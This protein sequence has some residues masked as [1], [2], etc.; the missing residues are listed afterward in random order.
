VPAEELENEEW[1]YYEDKESSN[2]LWLVRNYQEQEKDGFD[3]Y[4]RY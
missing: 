3:L 4:L 1:E 2:L